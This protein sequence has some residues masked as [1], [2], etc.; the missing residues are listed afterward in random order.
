[1][2]IHLEQ[3]KSALIS[4][5]SDQMTLKK[6]TNAF[7]ILAGCASW[8]SLMIALFRVSIYILTHTSE[9]FK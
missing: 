4:P 5:Q 7:D 2:K 6:M 3:W 9:M 8:I 1:M